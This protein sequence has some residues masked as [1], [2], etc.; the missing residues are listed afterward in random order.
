MRRKRREQR[1]AA[2]GLV[3]DIEHRA[4][5]RRQAVG[6]GAKVGEGWQGQPAALLG[7]LDRDRA[8]PLRIDPLD[9]AAPQPHGL[10][11]LHAQ[12]DRLL[13][14]QL[15][16]G[17]LERRE[18]QARPRLRRLRPQEL[19]GFDA[20]GPARLGHDHRRPF[21]IPAIEQGE[22]GA[23]RAAQHLA[24]IVGAGGRQI[25]RLAR[26]ERRLDEQTGLQADRS[27]QGAC[28]RGA[29]QA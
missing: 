8:H 2:A 14:Q 9:H 19:P 29:R 22:A 15:L 25:E 20:A 7:R 12:L 11:R 1:L 26:S 4:S 3:A 27:G 18:Q 21:A 6:E 13:H 10:E 5:R 16:A 28:S 17:A 23:E 24:E